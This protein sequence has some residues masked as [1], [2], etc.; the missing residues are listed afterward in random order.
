RS[1]IPIIKSNASKIGINKKPSQLIALEEFAVGT[2]ISDLTIFT[3]DQKLVDS[4]K[5]RNATPVTSKT[6][7]QLLLTL[8]DK[9]SLTIE[10]LVD[11]SFGRGRQTIQKSL[12]LLMGSG[13]VVLSDNKYSADYSIK[14]SVTDSI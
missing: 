14:D 6:N 11:L 1:M 10:E 2:G 3:V 12:D 8:L 9:G 13:L 7:I 5:R 4:R